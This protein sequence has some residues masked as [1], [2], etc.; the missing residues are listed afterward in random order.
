MDD[1]ERT[2]FVMQETEANELRSKLMKA[3]HRIQSLEREVREL[4]KALEYQKK[5]HEED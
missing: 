1:Y 4:E 2:Q 3:E 5:L